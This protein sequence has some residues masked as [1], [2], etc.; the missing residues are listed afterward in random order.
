[1][2]DAIEFKRVSQAVWEAMAPGWG[3]RH[4][5]IEERA[6]PVTERMLALL[7]PAGGETVLEI[8]AGTGVVGLAAAR[9]VSPGGRVVISDF[10]E[11]MVELSR[12]R[13][14]ALGLANVECRELD[15]ENLDLAS[16]SVDGVV[17]RW[18]YMLMGDPAKALAETRRVLRPGGRLVCAVFGSPEQNPWAA[19]PARVLRE[20][21]H[22]PPPAPGFSPGILALADSAHVCELLNDAGF[23]NPEVEEVHFTW[24][25]PAMD[26]YWA[27]LIDAAGAIAMVLRRLPEAELAEV[28]GE[29]AGRVRLAHG[30]QDI[31]LPAMSLVASARRA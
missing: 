31:E 22:L 20:R 9:L 5:Y 15:A 23:G 2:I 3:E 11:K 4:D 7:A 12:S 24:R 6:Q 19:L 17:C 1:M 25:F 13:A 16:G 30:A 10:S 29:I 18:G 14:R 27:F 26:D 28:R 21:G 8:A